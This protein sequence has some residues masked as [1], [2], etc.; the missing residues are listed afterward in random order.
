MKI[1]EKLGW[2]VSELK[3]R[4]G[5]SAKQIALKVGIDPSSFYRYMKGKNEPP[6]SFL[7][8]LQNA[9]PDLVDIVWF[10]RDDVEEPSSWFGGDEDGPHGKTKEAK[11]NGKQFTLINHELKRHSDF[12]SEPDFGDAVEGLREIYDSRDPVLIPAIEAN[13]RAFRTSSR[14]ERQI[15]QQ[16]AQIRQ[17]N[18]KCDGLIE[19]IEELDAKLDAHDH[20]KG[21]AA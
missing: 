7:T 11:V 9:Y 3:K 12:P 4:K 6:I 18:D 5:I 20:K 15:Q 14:R 19:R 10:I 8:K 2:L 1:H 21:E 17:I 13:I 16:Q